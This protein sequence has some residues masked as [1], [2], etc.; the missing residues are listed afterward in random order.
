[1]QPTEPDTRTYHFDIFADYHQVNLDDCGVR[2]AIS[3]GL[4]QDPAE[5]REQVAARMQRLEQLDARIARLVKSLEARAR[6][7][8]VAYGTLCI[9][10]AREFTVPVTIQIR[11]SPPPDDFAQWDRVVEA[12]V[13]TCR[14]AASRSSRQWTTGSRRRAS[15]SHRAAIAPASTTAVSPP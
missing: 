5:T 14:L 11:A 1:V 4:F 7:L 9:H 8:G 13:W 15:P 2:D 3:A 10:T 6:H 12:R